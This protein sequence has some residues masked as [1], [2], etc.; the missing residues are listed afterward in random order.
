ML[1]KLT[2]APE[3]LREFVFSTDAPLSGRVSVTVHSHPDIR[4]TDPTRYSRTQF[5][6]RFKR[7]ELAG[8]RYFFDSQNLIPLEASQ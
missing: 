5:V 6:L 3:H 2:R 1:V 7:N 8:T 4:L